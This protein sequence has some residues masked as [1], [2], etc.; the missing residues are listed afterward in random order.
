MA[1]QRSNKKAKQKF[2]QMVASMG[3][4]ESFAPECVYFSREEKEGETSVYV[5]IKTRGQYFIRSPLVVGE[6]AA[7]FS[8]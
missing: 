1:G 6:P 7:S 2:D 8:E 3:I 4:H 5:E